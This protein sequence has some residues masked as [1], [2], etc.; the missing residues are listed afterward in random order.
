MRGSQDRSV[1]TLSADLTDGRKVRLVDV[2]SGDGEL[3]IECET[4]VARPSDR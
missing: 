2:V 3:I 4:R 1:L